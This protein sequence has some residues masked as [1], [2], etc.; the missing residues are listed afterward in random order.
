MVETH[1]CFQ[2]FYILSKAA[3]FFMGVGG[4]GGGGGGGVV[5]GAVNIYINL[6]IISYLYHI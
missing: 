6:V 4:G 5:V 2:I 1:C 3:D